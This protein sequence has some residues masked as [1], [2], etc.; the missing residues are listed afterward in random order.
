VSSAGPFEV[1]MLAAGPENSGAGGSG[2][3]GL[4]EYLEDGVPGR[5]L[6]L[7]SAGS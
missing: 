4:P 7:T 1:R 2:R 3:T 6:P 5:G